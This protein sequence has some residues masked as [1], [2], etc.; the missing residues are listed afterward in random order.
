MYGALSTSTSA[1]VAQR[2]QLDV[3]TGN[4]AMRDAVSRGPDG[5]FEPYRRRVA[6]FSQGDPNHPGK[7]GVHVARIVED[8]APY[9]LKWDPY[10]PAAVKSGKDKGYVRTSAIDLHTEMVNAMV[11]ARSYEANVTVIEMM[12]SMAASTMRLMA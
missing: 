9:G 6:L 7:A 11:A 10:N 2:T 3:V 1:L 8:D 5:E 4:I 12:K